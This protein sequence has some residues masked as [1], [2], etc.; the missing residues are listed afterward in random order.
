MMRRRIFLW[1]G[2]S[3]LFAPLAFARKGLARET[4]QVQPGDTLFGIAEKVGVTP[5]P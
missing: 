5:T 4:Y 3:V 1:M 2:L